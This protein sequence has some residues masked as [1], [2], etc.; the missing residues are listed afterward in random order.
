[1]VIDFVAGDGRDRL[2]FPKIE[3]KEAVVLAV[4]F[5]VTGHGVLGGSGFESF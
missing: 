5:G 2:D 4:Y 3:V 1:M